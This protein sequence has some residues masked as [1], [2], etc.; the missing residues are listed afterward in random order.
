[1]LTSSRSFPNA[2]S[3]AQALRSRFKSDFEV[4][5]VLLMLLRE[6]G[7][8]QLGTDGSVVY[9]FN[10]GLPS[11]DS[12]AL[13]GLGDAAGVRLRVGNVLTNSLGSE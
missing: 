2:S 7:R 4:V 1:M 9:G 3:S 5:I 13:S 8:P 11:A 6:A 12:L 10:S